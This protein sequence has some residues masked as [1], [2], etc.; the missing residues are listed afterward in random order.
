MPRVSLAFFTAA[1]L[2][3]AVG[4]IWGAVMGATQDH[5]LSPAHAHLNLLG[6]VTLAIMGMFYAVS[7]GLAGKRLAWVNFALSTAGVL[8]FAPMLALVLREE[9]PGAFMPFP[10]LLV[11]GGMAVFVWQVASAWR[12]PRAG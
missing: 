11:M 1:T 6:F 10:E 3:G 4:M 7:P 9:L 8:L 12:T 5:S 2:M